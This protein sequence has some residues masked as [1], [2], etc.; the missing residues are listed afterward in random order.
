MNL[1]LSTFVNQEK[2]V[3]GYGCL[4]QSMCRCVSHF[5]ACLSFRF[6]LLEFLVCV[7]RS[8]QCDYRIK[9]KEHKIT[10]SK[11]RSL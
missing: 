4:G 1:L 5:M 3:Q 6:L 8:S 9:I 2:E 11:F 7:P 10:N